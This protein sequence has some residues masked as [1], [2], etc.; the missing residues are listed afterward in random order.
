[1]MCTPDGAGCALAALGPGPAGAAGAP[2][3]GRAFASVADA[4]QAGR[5]LGTYLNS[6]EIGRA[7]V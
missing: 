7:H 3:A 1:M 6:P 4:L 2:Q 5:A